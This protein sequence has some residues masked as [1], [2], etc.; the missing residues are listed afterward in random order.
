M[1]AEAL[2]IDLRLL[3]D[4][5]SGGL[6]N[7]FDADAEYAL[8]YSPTP[9]PTSF[10]ILTRSVSFFDPEQ[11]QVAFDLDSDSFQAGYYTIAIVPDPGAATLACGL[12]AAW[13]IGRALRRSRRP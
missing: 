3:F 8:L 2:R 10:S 12:A 13:V 7:L 4:W 6:G 9:S 11:R 5:N 1:H